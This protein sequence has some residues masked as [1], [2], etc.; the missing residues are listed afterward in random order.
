MTTSSR[1]FSGSL[2]STVPLALTSLKR[3]RTVI[4]PKC[5]TANSTCVCIGSI[6]Q[7]ITQP[8]SNK[9]SWVNLGG[10]AEVEAQ[11]L[12]HPERRARGEHVGRGQHARVLVDHG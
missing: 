5:L 4:I 6:C 11:R 8:P 9:L 2:G 12:H 7:G 1:D 10:E 3:P